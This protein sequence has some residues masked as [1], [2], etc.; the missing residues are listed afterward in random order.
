MLCLSLTKTKKYILKGIIMLSNESNE[1]KGE[2]KSKQ[3]PEE[4]II[5]MNLIFQEG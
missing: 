2:S 3:C 5:E 1:N 4:I